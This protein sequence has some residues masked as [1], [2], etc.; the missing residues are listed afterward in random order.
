MTLVDGS[1]FVGRDQFQGSGQ[2]QLNFFA[3]YDPSFT[4]WNSTI[5][6]Q[7]MNF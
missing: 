5:G 1:T 6:L 4:G 7:F 2:P 3:T